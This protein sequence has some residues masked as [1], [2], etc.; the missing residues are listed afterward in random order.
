MKVIKNLISKYALML[1]VPILLFVVLSIIFHGVIGTNNIPSLMQ[2]AVAP[3]ILGWGVLFNIKV[4]NWDFSV[5]SVVL[6]SA[7]IGG[8]IAVRLNWGFAGLLIF[9]LLVAVLAGVVVGLVYYFLKIPTIITSIGML[10]IY[11]SISSYA[12]EGQGIYLTGWNLLGNTEIVIIAIVAAAT[13]YLIFYRSSIGYN[14]RAVGNNMNIA[15]QNGLNV[16]RVKAVAI[17]IAGLFAGLYAFISLGTSGVQKTVSS[18]G[19]MGTCFD[20]M[21]CVF[22]GMSI[23]RRGNLVAGIFCGSLVMQLVKL[24]LMAI[25]IPSEY[26]SIFIA[27]FVLIF[28]TMDAYTN[29]RAPRRKKETAEAAKA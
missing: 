14:V 22:V 21:M 17:A 23:T 15:A 26:N 18:M 29:N 19:T 6:L 11:E 4:G 10:L 27:I 28:M 12:F 13:A 3:A 20:A 24:A 1:A 25:G 5:G 16:Y 9:C 8:N 2:Q 7:I